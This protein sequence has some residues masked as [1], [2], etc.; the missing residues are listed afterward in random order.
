M[1]TI[2]RI[3]ECLSVVTMLVDQQILDIAYSQKSGTKLLD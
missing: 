2:P 3:A 1:P